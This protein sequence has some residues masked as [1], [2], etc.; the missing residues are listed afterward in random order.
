MIRYL[1]YYWKMNLKLSLRLFKIDKLFFL[2]YFLEVIKSKQV[3]DFYIKKDKLMVYQLYGESFIFFVLFVFYVDNVYGCDCF[4][5]GLFCVCDSIIGDVIFCFFD[6]RCKII[7][8]YIMQ[9]EEYV[10]FLININYYFD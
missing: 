5:F 4:F 6:C 3:C 9:I 10:Y 1:I 8:I 7:L 2:I